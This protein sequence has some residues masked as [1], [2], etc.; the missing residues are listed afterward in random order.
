MIFIIRA[1]GITFVGNYVI[2]LSPFLY[3]QSYKNCKITYYYGDNLI[4][5]KMGFRLKWEVL[6]PTGTD[7]KKS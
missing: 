3:N 4:G 5:G 6:N 7:N 1:L 2:Q